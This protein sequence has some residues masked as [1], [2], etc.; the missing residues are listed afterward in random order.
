MQPPERVA[1]R[2][3]QVPRHLHDGR[4]HG[5]E[6]RRIEQDPRRLDE[7]GQLG[8]EPAAQADVLDRGDVSGEGTGR[9]SQRDGAQRDGDRAAVAAPAAELRLPLGRVGHRRGE[10]RLDGRPVLGVDRRHEAVP[11]QLLRGQ[12]EHLLHAGIGVDAAAGGVRHEHPRGKGV[13]ERLDR[14]DASQRAGE[15]SL[16]R[17]C[18][19]V[20]RHRGSLRDRRALTL[21]PPPI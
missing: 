5:V 10:L 3:D 18:F 1:V 4:E 9:T 13:A 20:G 8:V 16:E 15:R 14:R 12:A 19:P 17:R 7:R 21:M 6:A 11:R 2:G